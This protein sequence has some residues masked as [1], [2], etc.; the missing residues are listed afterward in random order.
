MPCTPSERAIRLAVDTFHSFRSDVINSIF[1]YQELL[2]FRICAKPNSVVVSASFNQ[3]FC[4]N[5][6]T[7]PGSLYSIAQPLCPAT[8]IGILRRS[9]QSE[10]YHRLPY[11]ALNPG[12]VLQSSLAGKTGN[13]LATIRGSRHHPASRRFKRPRCTWRRTREMSAR[14]GGWKAASRIYDKPLTA[15]READSIGLLTTEGCRVSPTP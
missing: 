10:P 12:I 2:G 4:P 1:R 5:F 11:A 8:T 13:K 9:S 15:N 3:P 7:A 6:L 14:R